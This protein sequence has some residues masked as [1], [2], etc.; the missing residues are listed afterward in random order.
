MKLLLLLLML[1]IQ[2]TFSPRAFA[3]DLRP[4]DIL[5]QPLSCWACSL[6]EGQE[7]TI[8][9][10]MAIVVKTNPVLVG[11]AWQGVTATPL[12]E[13]LQKTEKGQ[14]V[15]IIRHRTEDFDANLILDDFKTFEGL[16]YDAAFSWS[17]E[18]QYCSE[19]VYKLLLNYTHKLPAPKPM[20]FDYARKHWIKYFNGNVPDGELGISPGDFDRSIEFKTIG[21]L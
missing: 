21:F 9:S 19:L 10:H 18:A 3:I 13:F 7:K 1:S 20:R 16:P 4:G 17:D 15:R 8:Y 2:V 14:Q 12:T 11:E 5:L 6:I